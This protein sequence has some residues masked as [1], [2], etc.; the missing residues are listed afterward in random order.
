MTG[1][2]WFVRSVP[3]EL[4]HRIRHEAAARDI[5]IADYL[6]RLV[7][8]HTTLIEGYG[9]PG[10]PAILRRFIEALGLAPVTR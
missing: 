4:R 8:L 10:E 1:N 6:G 7:A 9:A 3:V 5:T 2:D